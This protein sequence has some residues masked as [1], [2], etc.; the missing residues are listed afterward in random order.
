MKDFNKNKFNND[1]NSKA[2]EVCFNCNQK[3]HFSKEC[4]EPKKKNTFFHPKDK[5]PSLT[6]CFN[7]N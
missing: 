3:G 7:C 4:P 2:E 1:K 6:K 5:D